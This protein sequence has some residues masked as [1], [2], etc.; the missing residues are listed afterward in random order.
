MTVI[1]QT[2]EEKAL[3]WASIGFTDRANFWATMTLVE[4]I[5]K[6]R[7]ELVASK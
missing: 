2:S 6:L 3:H 4:E 7:E 5:K 1:E